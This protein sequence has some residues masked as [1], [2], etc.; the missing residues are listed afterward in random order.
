M[1]DVKD[2]CLYSRTSWD[3]SVIHTHIYNSR[4]LVGSRDSIQSISG[5]LGVHGLFFSNCQMA[6]AYL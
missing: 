5:K 4:I 1:T 6:C 3:F 2:F